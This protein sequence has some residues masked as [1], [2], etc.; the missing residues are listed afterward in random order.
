MIESA[1]TGI[2]AGLAFILTVA[3]CITIFL[4]FSRDRVRWSAG[5]LLSAFQAHAHQRLT[6]GYDTREVNYII[7]QLSQNQI[8]KEIDKYVIQ[9][10][11]TLLVS[12]YDSGL[13]WS[14]TY[15]PVIVS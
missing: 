6:L 4:R 1:L 3:I 13:M 10:Q 12:G 7:E 8:P 5:Q 15:Y 2:V 14:I 9:T 11:R